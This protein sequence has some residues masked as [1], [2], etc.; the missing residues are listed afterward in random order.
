MVYV[1]ICCISFLQVPGIGLGLVHQG[2]KV[3]MP[4]TLLKYLILFYQNSCHI[5]HNGQ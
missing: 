5:L 1:L 4:K 2:G 3:V